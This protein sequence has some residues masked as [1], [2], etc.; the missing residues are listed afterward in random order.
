MRT[1]EKVLLVLCLVVAGFFGGRWVGET[2]TR[3]AVA[4]ICYGPGTIGVLKRATP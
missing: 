3:Q 2:E 4:P 1:D